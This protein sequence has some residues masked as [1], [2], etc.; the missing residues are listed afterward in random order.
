MCSYLQG[1]P[2]SSTF[3][4]HELSHIQ[5]AACLLQQSKALSSILLPLLCPNQNI[6]PSSSS[7]YL[8]ALTLSNLCLWILCKV[9]QKLSLSLSLSSRFL[10]HLGL[11]CALYLYTHSCFISF[12]DPFYCSSYSDHHHLWNN[13]IK[14]HICPYLYFIMYCSFPFFLNFIFFLGLS[15]L[16][17]HILKDVPF[18]YFN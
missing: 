10:W 8:L 16:I 2:Q 12:S 9:S 7:S 6:H 1:E 11:I 4:H 5:S 3:L 15:N 14:W 18:Y 17:L 13:I